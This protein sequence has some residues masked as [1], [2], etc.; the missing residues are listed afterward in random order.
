MK[1]P[2]SSPKVLPEPSEQE[3]SD[4][5]FHL[6]QK[7]NCEAGHDLENWREAIECLKAN[8]PRT[9]LD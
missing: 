9:Q 1:K 6:Y 2:P 4:Y 3:I 7:S 8:I 5:A